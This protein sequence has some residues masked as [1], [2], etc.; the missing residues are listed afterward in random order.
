MVMSQDVKVALY[1]N[2]EMMSKVGVTLPLY[3]KFISF[4]IVSVPLNIS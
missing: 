1:P 2:D 3:L 4:I